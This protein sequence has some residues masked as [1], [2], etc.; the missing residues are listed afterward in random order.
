MTAETVT[1][2]RNYQLT[3]PKEIREKVGLK[4][5]DK[6]IVMYENEKIIILPKKKKVE[7]LI[8]KYGFGKI[9]EIE[10]LIGEEMYGGS[11]W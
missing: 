11:N 8:G 5:G 4:I 9:E 10:E 3:I 1:I 2:T 7:D 6:V